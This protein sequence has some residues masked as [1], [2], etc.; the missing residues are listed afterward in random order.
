MSG[1]RKRGGGGHEN[2]ERWLLTWAD[3]LTLLLALFIVMYASASVNTDKAKAITESIQQAFSGKVITGNGSI[4]PEQK[5]DEPVKAIAQIAPLA[6][7]VVSPEKLPENDREKAAGREEQKELEALKRRLD[8][9]IK[10]KGLGANV[11]TTVE[12]RGLVVRVVTDQILF[13]SGEATLS[14]KGDDLLQQIRS[15]LRIDRKHPIAV[16]GHTDSQ[17]ISTGRFR[18]N[19]E[20]SASRAAAVVQFLA[21]SELDPHRF[22]ATGHGDQQPLTSNGTPAGRQKNRR[23]EIALTRLHP[24]S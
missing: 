14:P 8:A 21:G 2:H 20:L 12:R 24:T 16:D 3:L 9:K 5:A 4:L 11:E 13:A 10:A 19:W 17:P 15:V 7:T 18:D 6:P 23:V 1:R 22:S